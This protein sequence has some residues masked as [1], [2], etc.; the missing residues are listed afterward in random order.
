[1]PDE[2]QRPDDTLAKED[3]AFMKIMIRRTTPS[4]VF[5]I[6]EYGVPW[7]AARIRR[8]GRCENHAWGIFESTGWRLV[9][10][11]K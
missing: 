2:W 4:R 7:I 6:D 9:G 3:L 11:R 1:M 5:E 10:P 8:R